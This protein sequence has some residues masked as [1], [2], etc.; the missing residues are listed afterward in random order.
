MY[1]KSGSRSAPTPKKRK[2]SST[3]KIAAEGKSQTQ[4]TLLHYFGTKHACAEDAENNFVEDDMAE[5][6]DLPGNA[7]GLTISA[8]A[9]LPSPPLE[10]IEQENESGENAPN[11]QDT[12]WIF[13]TPYY[14]R[15]FEEAVNEV[16]ENERYLLNDDEQQ[17]VSQYFCLTG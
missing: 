3:A 6:A 2:L 13:R 16:M 11:D 15:V 8:A 5:L 14:Q 9:T 4:G 7:C 12:S 1:C 10:E 17:I